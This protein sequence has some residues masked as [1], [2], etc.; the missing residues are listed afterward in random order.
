VEELHELLSRYLNFVNIQRRE[1]RITE[2][3][4]QRPPGSITPI[5]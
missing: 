2:A 5:D 4:Q 3:Q 1:A